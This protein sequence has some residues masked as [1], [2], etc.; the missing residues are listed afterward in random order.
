MKKSLLTLTLLIFTGVLFSQNAT[1]L[2][3]YRYLQTD[4][5]ENKPMLD[6]YSLKEVYMAEAYKINYTF[7]EFLDAD[8]NVKAI[9]CVA[10]KIKNDKVKYIVYPINN[11]QLYE[12]YYDIRSGLGV[13]L[14]YGYDY[15][16]GYFMSIYAFK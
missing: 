10:S 3:E 13:T 7:S 2:K 15:L 5:P 8:G 11:Q 12:K 14:G 4:Y 1:T 16:F 6:G 9:L